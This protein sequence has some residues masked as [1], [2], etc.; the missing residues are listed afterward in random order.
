MVTFSRASSPSS[1]APT[2]TRPSSGQQENPSH[3]RAARIA[4]VIVSVCSTDEDYR[5]IA[6]LCHAST[7]GVAPVTFRG[8]RRGE[9]VTPVGVL[10][11]ARVLRA[12]LMVQREGGHP[13]EYLNA[14]YRTVRRLLSRGSLDF[15]SLTNVSVQAFLQAQRF[16]QNR[17]VIDEVLKLL[18]RDR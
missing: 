2:A 7:V 3:P 15:D 6:E 16:V 14:D 4:M 18:R 11:F 8:W 13:R 17:F 9:V 12:V 1:I 10:G 5:T